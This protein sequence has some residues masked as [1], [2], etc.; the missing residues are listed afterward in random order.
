[1][2]VLLIMPDQHNPSFS[3]CYGGITET[4]NIDRLANSGVR[5]DC[6]YS[7]SP[8]CAPAR[9]A[10]F[11]G[12]YVFENGFW[13]NA[14]PYDGKIEN[15]ARH[16][17]ENG[18][19]VSVIGKLDFEN[20]KSIDYGY[21]DMYVTKLRHNLDSTGLF[22]DKR[23]GHR[24]GAVGSFWNTHAR[25]E[26]D[27]TWDNDTRITE[28]AEEW[29]LGEKSREDKDWILEV[30]YQHPHPKWRP[31]P[32]LFEK[33][34]KK[35][36]SLA[37]KYY[38]RSQELNEP[39]RV[40]ADYYMGYYG[41]DE[42]L[43]K[44]HAGYH[45]TIEEFDS[46]VGRVLDALERGGHKED[47]MIIYT[48]D[49]GEMARAHGQLGKQSL[50]EDSV[51]IPLIFSGAASRRGKVIK[52]PVSMM[53]IY[54]TI[55]KFL[56]LP[57]AV[58]SRGMV[59]DKAVLGEK[60]Y[61]VPEFVF[62]EMHCFPRYCGTFAIRYGKYKLIDYADKSVNPMLFDMEKDPDE[63]NDLYEK[64]FKNEE[65]AVVLIKMRKQLSSLCSKSAVDLRAK[66]EQK[67][68]IEKYRK[69]GVLQK[70]LKKREFEEHDG[71]LISA[72]KE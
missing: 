31:R 42:E 63:M 34:L 7:P 19:N 67:M 60:E 20:D 55:N 1:M 23:N 17:K 9:A 68:I 66:L 5:F 72:G 43:L 35:V 44:M 24:E 45:A 27:T 46:H 15:W 18:V 47:T 11:T 58:F 39:E 65:L 8:L 29:L 21:K 51:R 71:I 10:M 38:Q 16:F 12:R 3:G 49:H 2:K 30:H 22:R 6:C 4:P 33:Y 69:S 28:K 37:P 64:T 62:S 13:D 26:E 59:L 41:A 57:D 32:E 25:D 36:T 61:D 52:E 40:H 14:T 48:S 70:E 56:G 50:Y 54:P 53:D